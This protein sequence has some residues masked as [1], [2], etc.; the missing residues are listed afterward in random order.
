MSKRFR[1][2]GVVLAAVVMLMAFLASVGVVLTFYVRAANQARHERTLRDS[3]RFANLSGAAYARAHAERWDASPPADPVNLPI[4]ALLPPRAT[5]TTTCTVERDGD[6]MRCRITTRM[7]RFGSVIQ[8][9]LEI[10]LDDAP[11]SS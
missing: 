1:R 2:R 10:A 11:G 9:S 4:D 5:G 6:V 8:E 7:D 3:V